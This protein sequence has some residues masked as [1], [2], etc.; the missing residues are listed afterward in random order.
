MKNRMGLA[1]LAM[2]GCLGGLRAYGADIEVG[3]TLQQVIAELGTPSGSMAVGSYKLLYYE[4]GKV[5]LSDGRVTGFDLVSAEVAEARRLERQLREEQ[6]RLDRERELARLFAEG[7]ARRL[8]VLGNADFMAS[9]AADRV[10]FWQDFR[11]RYPGVSLGSEYTQALQ[12]LQVE[13]ERQRAEAE[14]A[15]YV[16]ALERRVRDAEDRAAEAED[17]ARRSRSS[18]D[19][20]Y[21]GYGVVQP[22][23]Y[24]SCYDR[25]YV[26][27][28]TPVCVE[29]PRAASYVRASFVIGA[30]PSVC[31]APSR[32]PVCT[33]SPLQA[34][35]RDRGAVACRS[36]YSGRTVW[37]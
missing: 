34:M 12:E 30:G 18:W 1:V 23:I 13:R 29:T 7:S 28:V 17:R 3:D 8:E 15:G 20:P 32:L 22:V 11:K 4:R 21:Y 27:P 2:L 16:A 9:P 36:S 5:E 10:A 33:T 24:S 37:P 19:Y 25:P 35:G 31:V 26:R 6:E 14:R